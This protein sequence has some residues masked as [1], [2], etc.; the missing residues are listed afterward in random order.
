MVR[1]EVL[2]IHPAGMKLEDQMAGNLYRSQRRNL[3]H[4]PSQFC[5]LIKHQGES[6][7]RD[8]KRYRIDCL[9][10]QDTG[11][12][13]L[14][15]LALNYAEY[16]QTLTLGRDWTA[17][18]M[19]ATVAHRVVKS[20]RTGRKETSTMKVAVW[21]LI[22]KKRISQE[23]IANCQEGKEYM[24]VKVDAACMRGLESI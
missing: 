4:P 5:L 18:E 20:S 8:C 11:W 14:R 2:N 22:Q 1:A 13:W 19:T 16:C 21:N 15:Q 17:C 24:L 6:L 3:I 10:S 12:E 9:S 23:R 7:P